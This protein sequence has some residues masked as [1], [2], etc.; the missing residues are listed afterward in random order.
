MLQEFLISSQFVEGIPQEVYY[1]KPGGVA[2]LW[3]LQTVDKSTNQ[4]RYSTQ[5]GLLRAALINPL[6]YELTMKAVV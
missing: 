2:S 6:L 4:P 1:E 3:L 5:Y